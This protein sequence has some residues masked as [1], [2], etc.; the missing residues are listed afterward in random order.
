MPVST[1]YFSLYTVAT[2]TNFIEA[3]S[4]SSAPIITIMERLIK[5][6][7]NC[8]AVFFF[9]LQENVVI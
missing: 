9:F 1:F 6:K 7:S 8:V 3:L 4:L 2:I 5:I